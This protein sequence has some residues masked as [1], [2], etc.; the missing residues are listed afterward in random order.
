MFKRDTLPNF[1]EFD[2]RLID[3]VNEDG[4]FISENS[5]DLSET[6]EIHNSFSSLDENGNLSDH[7][8]DKIAASNESLQNKTKINTFESQQLEGQLNY[9]PSSRSSR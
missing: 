5:F 9:S 3:N 1:N 2:Q 7:P 4:N 6:P 8:E